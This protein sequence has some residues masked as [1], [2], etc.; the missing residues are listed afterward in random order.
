MPFTRAELL[1]RGAGL[2]AG[3]LLGDLT[4][5]QRL[6]LAAREPG[7]AL[8]CGMDSYPYLSGPVRT[9]HGSGTT[10]ANLLRQA[11]GNHAFPDAHLLQN[12]TKHQILDAIRTRCRPDRPF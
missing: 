12:P 3:A 2:T 8:L 4:L 11:L 6:A 9:L 1:R 5:L 10:C 7:V